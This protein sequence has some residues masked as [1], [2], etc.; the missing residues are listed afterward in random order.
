MVRPWVGWSIMVVTTES[1]SVGRW[2]TGYCGTPR[3]FIRFTAGRSAGGG[4]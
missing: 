4:A 3:N 1:A 2:L